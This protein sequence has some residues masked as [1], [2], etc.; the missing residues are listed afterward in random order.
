MFVC[1]INF[2]SRDVQ[3]YGKYYD[4][5]SEDL[6]MAFSGVV[7]NLGKKDLQ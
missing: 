2:A 3:F 7:M 5:S 6:L 4:D 1:K